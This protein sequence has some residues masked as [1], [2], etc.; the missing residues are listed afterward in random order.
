MNSP[1]IK[2]KKGTGGIQ[3]QNTNRGIRLFERRHSILR[4]SRSEQT[5]GR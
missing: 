4:L 1:R 2:T 3:T 5:T